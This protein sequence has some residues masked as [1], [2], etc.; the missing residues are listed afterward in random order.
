MEV[1]IKIDE[2]TYSNFVCNKYSRVDVIAMHTALANGTQ[3]PKGHGDL[4]DANELV[5]GRVSNDPIVILVNN[6]ET[7]IEAD[8]ESEDE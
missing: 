2:G 6:A 7:I 4:I 8:I 3:L 5:K 1:V